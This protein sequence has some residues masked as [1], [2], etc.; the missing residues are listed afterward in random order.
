MPQI[1]PAGE[2]LLNAP[3]G[4]V[5]WTYSITFCTWDGAAGCPSK[6]DETLRF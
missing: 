3:A 6:A 2:I 1:S 4:M 5:S